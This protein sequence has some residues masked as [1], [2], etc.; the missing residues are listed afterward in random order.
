MRRKKVE[1]ILQRPDLK[2][3][4]VVGVIMSMQELEGRGAS[5]E[6]ATAA[7]HKMIGDQ[8]SMK[9][10]EV[11]PAVQLVKYVWQNSFV[12]TSH[13]WRV[14]NECLQDALLLAI[15]AG[16]KF[17]PDDFEYIDKNFRFYF[18]G[19]NDGHMLGEGFLFK[20]CEVS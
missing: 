14:L 2:E 19:G 1:E 7:Y 15:M 9:T 12:C 4:L 13:S 20:S 11:S 16:M 8:M 18:W 6:T 5:K 3:R 17:D 10:E